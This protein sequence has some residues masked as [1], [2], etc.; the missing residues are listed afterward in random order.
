LKNCSLFGAFEK[1]V[2]EIRFQLFCD[3][4]GADFVSAL[5]GKMCIRAR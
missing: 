3:Y 1:E 2:S 4:K 5:A